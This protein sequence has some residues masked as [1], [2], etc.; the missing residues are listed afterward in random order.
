[1]KRKSKLLEDVQSSFIPGQIKAVENLPHPPAATRMPTV[2]RIVQ[3]RGLATETYG[4]QD[5]HPAVITRVHTADPF[6][7]VNLKVMFD[8]G[9]IESRTTIEHESKGAPRA[10]RWPLRA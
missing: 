2:C 5:W 4:G 3:Y 9:P 7:A 1:M 10:W 6:A 8:E